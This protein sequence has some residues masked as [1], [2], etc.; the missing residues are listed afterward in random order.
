MC[1]D[2]SVGI[3]TRYGLDGPGIESRWERDFPHPYIPAL[4]P[5]P[6]PIQ[7]VR[8]L[9]RVKAAGAW[10]WTPIPSSA[11]IKERVELYLYSSSGTSWP[12]IGWTS[13][14]VLLVICVIILVADILQSQNFK[15]ECMRSVIENYRLWKILYKRSILQNL[16]PLTVRSCCSKMWVVET[17]NISINVSVPYGFTNWVVE[18]C[19]TSGF[20]RGVVE[21]L[22]I[23]FFSLFHRAF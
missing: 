14:V 1:R 10:R 2:S 23:L 7:W 19:E 21:D 4:W 8:V 6:P 13:A 15:L 16:L 9:S 18:L 17:D 22:D 20:A 3:A 11:E 12:V 5:I